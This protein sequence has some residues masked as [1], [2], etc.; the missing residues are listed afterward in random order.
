M[1]RLLHTTLFLELDA[2]QRTT[3]MT[4]LHTGDCAQGTLQVTYYVYQHRPG[5]Q[6][7]AS[8]VI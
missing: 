5:L 7:K 8:G 3:L 6:A 1:D 2:K 4:T